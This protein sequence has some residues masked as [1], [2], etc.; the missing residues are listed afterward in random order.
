[1]KNDV[2]EVVP[3]S[4]RKFVVTSKQIYKIKHGADGSIK[5]DNVRFVAVGFTQKE[6]EDYDDIFSLVARYNTI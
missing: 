4:E 1:M 3:R 6:G 2:W 5:K